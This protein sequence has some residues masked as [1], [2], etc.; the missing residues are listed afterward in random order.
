MGDDDAFIVKLLEDAERYISRMQAT[1]GA[2]ELRSRLDRYRD[3]VHAWSITPPSG[4]Q[5]E[6][7]RDQLS[8]LVRI[9][10]GAAPTMKVRRP[11]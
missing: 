10:K 3:A 7:L 9:A 2:R 8:E 4:E 5:R 6:A 11:E 1:P